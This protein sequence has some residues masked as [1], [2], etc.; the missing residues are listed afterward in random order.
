MAEPIAD[1]LRY[2][3]LAAWHAGEGSLPEL[4]QRFQVSAGWAAK[5]RQQQR[6]TGHV[7]RVLQAAERETAASQKRRA[8]YAAAIAA[9]APERLVFLDESGV[10]TSMTRLY[11]RC[12]GGARICEGT[13][14]GRW[15]VLTILGA[16]SIDGVRAMM[17]IEAAAAGD[18]FRA[19]L[20]AVL[21]PRL[22]PGDV[23]VL[24]NLSAR[25]VAGVRETIGRCGARLL[26]LPPCSPDLNPIEKAWS[27]LKTL[28]RTA[29]ARS[30][31]ALEA[32]IASS[33]PALT[34]ND[35]R[36]WFHHAGIALQQV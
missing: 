22:K 3:L 36:A 25:K 26:Y 21:A 19:S 30:N 15:S 35:A 2:R 12:E 5:I 28:L 13:P 4:A 10:T 20:T 17:T 7:E 18:V 23:V 34:A 9:I 33:L 11:G 16:L 8:E 14:G 31:E 24:D 27:K 29:K 32:A 6:R 1:D